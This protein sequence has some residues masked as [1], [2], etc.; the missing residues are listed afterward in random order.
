MEVQE[1]LHGHEEA[2]TTDDPA[3]Q[4][5]KWVFDLRHVCRLDPW[6]GSPRQALESPAVGTMN[7]EERDVRPRLGEIRMPTL[8]TS[9]RFDF[10]SPTTVEF[11]R[12]GIPGSEWVLFEKSSHYPHIEETRRYL[13]ILNG[14]LARVEWGL[15]P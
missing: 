7:V 4:D 9:G 15:N 13:A 14:F 1:T 8:I 6:L 10:C 2:G 5:A 11:V 3:Y 12:R